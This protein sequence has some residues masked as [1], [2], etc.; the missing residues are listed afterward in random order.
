MSK[1]S[2]QDRQGAFGLKQRWS[3]RRK[4]EVELR[5]LWGEPLDAVSR[6]VGGGEIYRLEQWRDK[7]F[8]GV[9]EALNDRTGA[10]KPPFLGPV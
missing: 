5:L 6:E 1:E 9:E 7:E 4:R 2:K 10:V 3:M 8:I